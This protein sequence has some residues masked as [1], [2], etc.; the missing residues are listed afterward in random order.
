MEVHFV[1]GME[2]WEGTTGEG[3]ALG[4]LRGRTDDHCLDRGYTGEPTG[5]N[6]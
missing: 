6:K 2:K 1:V 4:M 5:S 3:T